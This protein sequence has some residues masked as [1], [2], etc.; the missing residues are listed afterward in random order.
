MTLRVL[1]FGCELHVARLIQR[2]QE[3]IGFEVRIVD[4]N[5]DVGLAF[6][7]LDP[8]HII[9]GTKAAYETVKKIAEKRESNAKIARFR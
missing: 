5:G 6:T 7:E 3:R 8:T 9:A 2:Q 1:V 4:E